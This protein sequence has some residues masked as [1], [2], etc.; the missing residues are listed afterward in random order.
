MTSHVKEVPYLPVCKVDFSSAHKK[1]DKLCQDDTE[2]TV[3]KVTKNSN[4]TAPSSNEIQQFSTGI[5][6]S[7]SK[8][9]IL[10]I[11]LPF[12]NEFLPK[13]TK[14]PDAVTVSYNEKYMESNYIELLGKCHDIHLSVTEAEC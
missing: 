4:L 5:A 1:Q 13:N 12:N 3:P 11:V 7:G 6:Q 10:F 14:L 2:Q 8:S 9:I